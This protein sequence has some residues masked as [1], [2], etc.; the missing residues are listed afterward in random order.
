MSSCYDGGMAKINPQKTPL[1]V[2]ILDGFG[3][4]AGTEGNAIAHADT[5]CLDRC[6]EHYAW[7]L[8]EGAGERVGLP[9][10]Q[11]G[12]SEVGHLNLGA[13]RVVKM[14]ITR[15]DEA[16]ESGRFFENPALIAAVDWG[17]KRAL[18]LMGL[19][20]DGGVHSRITH[21]E[22][23]LELAARRGVERVYLHCFTD[24]R[25]TPPTSGLGYLEKLLA[26]T[27]QLQLGRLATICGRYYAMDRDNRWERIQRAYQA[28]TS[29]EGRHVTDPLAA[30]RAGYEIGVTDEFVEPMVIVDEAGHPAAT[31]GAGDSVIFFNFR[32]DRARQLTRAFTGLH[33]DRFARERIPDLHFATFTQYDRALTAP[34]IFPPLKLDNTLGEI[35]AREEV[36]N[37]RAA[38]TEKYAHV[39]YF[40]NG[41]VEKQHACEK[42]LLVPS[43]AVA[44][45][46]LRPEMSAARLTDQ[47]CRAIEQNEAEVYLVNYA[48]CDMVGHTGKLPETIKAVE[49]VDGCLARLLE[50]I[51]RM[52][53]IAVITSDH[54]NCEQMNDPET[55]TPHTAHTANPVPFI[56]CDPGFQGRLRDHG[57][58][59]D[60]APTILDLLGIARPE[61]MTGRSLIK[62]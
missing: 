8:I 22:A 23:L 42:R 29:G 6:Y 32:S 59:E 51:G 38:E 5:P 57:A 14:D 37:L 20:S 60:V 34:I 4:A 26:R 41:G 27:E 1:A 17:K 40:F 33:F 44:T 55:G 24:G 56:L 36:T 12:N 52:G 3:Y 19:L 35:L 54:G 16:I 45:Y 61:E 10:G 49:T 31:I 18:H 15:I 50:T 53:G 7:T 9:R 25:D 2:I 43:P 62:T 47:L 46:D 28:M 11:F 39:T 21:L 30:L 48:N 58:L 13:G